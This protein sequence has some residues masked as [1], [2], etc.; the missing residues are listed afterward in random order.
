MGLKRLQ[1]RL[2][3]RL[4][5]GLKISYRFLGLDRALQGNNLEST[6]WV[7]KWDA[8]TDLGTNLGANLGSNLGCSKCTAGGVQ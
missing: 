5:K 6:D 8:G 2:K 3:R 1:L 4:I 7:A